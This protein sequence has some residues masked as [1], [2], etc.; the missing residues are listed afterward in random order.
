MPVARD[1]GTV[2]RAAV[3]AHPQPQ[4]GAA[5]PERSPPRRKAQVAGDLGI[6]P[7]LT[8]SR[9]WLPELASGSAATTWASASGANVSGAVAVAAS[10]WLQPGR[11]GGG[12]RVWR[13]R[14]DGH[15]HP[16]G[17]QQSR[18][19]AA[20]EPGR[21]G[22]LHGRLFQPAPAFVSRSSGTKASIRVSPGEA[23]GAGFVREGHLVDNKTMIWT[24]PE[25]RAPGA[26]E[27]NAPEA[28]LNSLT[29]SRD[30]GTAGGP[31]SPTQ[32]QSGPQCIVLLHFPVLGHPTV[33]AQP[34]LR[35]R[36]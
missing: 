2:L 21:T 23:T 24:D 12:A 16:Q 15:H 27:Q 32:M 3:V 14:H 11:R 17:N 10:S 31:P 34:D 6:R 1:V 18:A 22:I 28:F 7:P 30:R 20:R 5:A 26:A 19:K 33:E 29:L 36:D 8:S 13:F 35:P 9:S 25:G 4:R